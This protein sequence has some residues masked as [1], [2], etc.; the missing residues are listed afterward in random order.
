MGSRCGTAYRGYT[1]KK[2]KVR[3]GYGVANVRRAVIAYD[4]DM[5]MYVKDGMFVTKIVFYKA[6]C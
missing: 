2:D 4:S 3:Y 6:V 5:E 1:S